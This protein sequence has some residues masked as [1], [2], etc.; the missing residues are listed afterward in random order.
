MPLQDTVIPPK[1]ANQV[2][3]HF[4]RGG[5]PAGSWKQ[6]LIG[7]LASADREN[8]ALLAVAFPEYAAAVDIAKYDLLGIE[9]LQR[10]ARGGETA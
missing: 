1:V 4:G 5:Y 10:I 7:L 3:D 9:N 6:K 8:F 2:L